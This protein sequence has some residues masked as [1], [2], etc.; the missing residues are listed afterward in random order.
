MTLR[1]FASLLLIPVTIAVLLQLPNDI[2]LHEEMVAYSDQGKA[3]L[4]RLWA[5]TATLGT[6]NNTINVSSLTVDAPPT[7]APPTTTTTTTVVVLNVRCQEWWTTAVAAGWSNDRIPVLLDSIIWRES[8]CL[9]HVDND[10][11]DFGL[12]QVNWATWGDMVTDMGLTQDDLYDPLH[13]LTVALKISEE[14]EAI[15]WKWCQPWH[16]SGSHC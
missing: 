1:W 7:T 16:Y 9:P 12:T 4:Q 11:K 15:G 10:E 6:V 3:E 5:G 13:N 8:R 2:E 14:A